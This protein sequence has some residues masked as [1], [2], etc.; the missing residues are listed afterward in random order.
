[1]KSVVSDSS[2]QLPGVRWHVIPQPDW[3]TL[4]ILASN[5]ERDNLDFFILSDIK[6]QFHSNY[7][8]D[9]L[10]TGILKAQ[11]ANADILL[12]TVEA[13]ESAIQIDH[14][15]FWIDKFKGL[16]FVI[17]FKQFYNRLLQANENDINLSPDHFLSLITASKLLLYPFISNPSEKPSQS[18]D[19]SKTPLPSANPAAQLELLVH[20]KKHYSSHPTSY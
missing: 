10:N 11:E 7:K 4:C 17:I 15:L 19:L 12:G 8:K 14:N 16:S 18:S 2:D 1:M 5:A 9:H 20:I 13:F 6:Y 3:T